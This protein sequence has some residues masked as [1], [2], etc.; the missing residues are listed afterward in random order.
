MVRKVLHDTYNVPTTA[1]VKMLY[2][3]LKVPS[4][5]G[6]RGFER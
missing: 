3:D 6:G 1:I 5:L 2:I 4:G